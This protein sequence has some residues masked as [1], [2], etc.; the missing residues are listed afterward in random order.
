MG[1]IIDFTSLLNA[2]Q[3]VYGDSLTITARYWSLALGLSIRPLDVA[4]LMALLKIARE[5][6]GGRAKETDDSVTDL[7]GYLFLAIQSEEKSQ[8]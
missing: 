4:V 2:K 8:Q 1:D 7:I 3:E 5:V 6:G